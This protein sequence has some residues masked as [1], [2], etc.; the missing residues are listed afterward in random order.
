[1]IDLKQFP[2]L[3]ANIAKCQATLAHY[4]QQAA[5]HSQCGQQLAQ[6][7]QAA[8]AA[9]AEAVG[10]KEKAR[11]LLRELMGKP[12]KKMHE[13]RASER[14]AYSLAEDYRSFM[15]ELELAR[16]EAE[17][18]ADEA[19]HRYV[20]ARNQV[21][22]AYA[23][24]LMQQ[25][26]PGLDPLLAALKMQ[27][28]SLLSEGRFASWRQVGYD[29]A[30][31]AVLAKFQNTLQQRLTSYQTINDPVLAAMPITDTI[32]ERSA[33]ISPGK[34]KKRNEALNARKQELNV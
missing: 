14:A 7:E 15:V 10:F 34:W 12:D 24:I 23:D 4:E 17:L 26:L 9:E 16:D 28:R 11:Q 6:Q 30:Q 29:S 32:H 21:I 20:E 3:Q 22:T 33:T 8:Q 19:A 2:E 31:A 13:L 27:E 5:L 18:A 1:M 25:A